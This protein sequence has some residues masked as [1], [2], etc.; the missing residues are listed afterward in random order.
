MA[1]RKTPQITTTTTST[2]T[3][4]SGPRIRTTIK[5][6]IV[7]FHDYRRRLT[8]GV[9]KMTD[10]DPDAEGP[11]GNLLAHN[12]AKAQPKNI[13]EKFLAWSVLGGLIPIPFVDIG[14]IAVANY[15]MVKQIAEYYH[16]D[17]DSTKTKAIIAAVIAG[18]LPQSLAAG[19]PGA[20]VRMIPVVGPVINFLIEPG[21][22][23]L[24][25]Y[26]VAK[27]AIQGYATSGDLGSINRD[28][29]LS[30]I[31]LAYDL[32]GRRQF[33]VDKEAA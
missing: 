5:E 6:T 17:F 8:S 1:A 19:I 29:V 22:A 4:G 27:L 7:P 11:E 20:M 13:W 26:V 3:T 14:A 10:F 24:V 32:G 16:Q 9:M 15:F 30:Q 25:T 33:I 31:Q 21:F 2:K 23:A 12:A 28:Y 18:V